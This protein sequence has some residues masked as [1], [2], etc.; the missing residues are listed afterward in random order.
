MKIKDIDWLSWK[1]G[2]EAVISYILDGDNVLLIHKKK[3]LGAGKIN[4]PGGHIEEGETPLIAA[5]RETEEE[6]GLITDNL[7]FS[8][9]LFFHFTDGLKLRGTVFICRDFKGSLIETDEALPFWCPLE[10]I[11]WDRMWEDDRHW[12]PQALRGKQFR[13]RFIFDGDDML[14]K[15][16]IFYESS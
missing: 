11:P 3:G 6:V 7:I 15:E 5:V 13:G 1:P 10:D 12:L 8:G 9:D 14:D 2:E 4:A 16:I